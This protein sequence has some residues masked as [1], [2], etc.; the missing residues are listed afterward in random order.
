VKHSVLIALAGFGIATSGVFGAPEPPISIT[1]EGGADLGENGAPTT[2]KE[3][4]K[5]ECPAQNL[6]IECDRL[7][8]FFA[9]PPQARIRK[10]IATGNV[11]VRQAGGDGKP[12]I[13]L[14]EKAVFDAAVKTTTVFGD[15]EVV[16]DVGSDYLFHA[17]TVTLQPNGNHRLGALPRTVF[18]KSKK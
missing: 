18:R 4:V 14:G 2:Y 3:K 15:P 13:A 8:V 1:S 11:V 7:E 16:L 6:T 9:P 10:A 12:A 17:E 5:F